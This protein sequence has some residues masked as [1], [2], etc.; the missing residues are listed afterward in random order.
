MAR[1]AVPYG[2]AVVAVVAAAAARLLLDPVLGPYRLPFITFFAAVALAAWY[3][4]RGPGLV[5]IVLSYL[6]AD[7]LYL[8]PRGSILTADPT[9]E[10]VIGLVAFF[11]VSGI[12]VALSD[13]LRRAHAR[14]ETHAL[15][16]ARQTQLIE[17]TLRSIGDAVIATDREGTISFMNPVAESLT[18][19]TQAEARERPLADVFHIVN[20]R[21]RAPAE[22]PHDKVLR[23]GQVVGL[24][25]HTVLISRHG[26]ERPIADSAAPI[27]DRA[28]HVLGVVIVF[29]DASEGRTAAQ[30]QAMLAAIVASSDDA[31]IS[32]SL[33]GIITSWNRGAERVFGYTAEEAIG[34]P[35]AMLA[36]PSKPE[37]M[38]QI[39]ERIRRGEHLDHFE[40]TRRRKD[41]QLV[42]IS[43]TVSPIRDEFGELIGASKVARDITE[44]KRGRDAVELALA[45]AERANRLKDEFLAVL[46]H[47]IRTP[48]NAILGWAQVL[49]GGDLSEGDRNEG[50]EVIE[51]NARAQAQLIA[52]L[53]DMS[54]IIS[55]RIELDIKPIDLAAVIDSTLVSLRP[56]AEARK[57]E[58]VRQFAHTGLVMGD[59]HRLQ[60]IVWNLLSNA[61]KFTPPG[62]QVRMELTRSDDKVRIVVAD[63]GQGIEPHFLPH[64]FE[65]FRQADS[66]STRTHGGLGLGLAI[67][68]HLVELHRGEI[69]AESGGPGQ[70]STFTVTLP[71]APALTSVDA[72][73]ASELAAF[74]RPKLDGLRVL[75]VDDESDARGLLARLF[76]DCGAQVHTAASV[77][78][79]LATIDSAPPDLLVSDIGMPG[80]D[81]YELIRRVRSLAADRGGRIPAVALTAFARSSDRT[82][83]LLAGYDSHLA[84]PIEPA[85][86]LAVVA[87]LSD[88]Q[89]RA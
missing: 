63:N 69:A 17:V 10:D 70:G 28:G 73:P 50:L 64:V 62:G 74:Q 81:G 84:K 36:D 85:E 49:R 46:S 76:A 25:N 82:R 26:T 80:V 18:G 52:D 30:A 41:G 59:G 39:L 15:L 1:R 54:R 53:L 20:E 61:I 60:Q 89:T 35:I 8:P 75:V 57:I 67:V 21:T 23:S 72:T 78:E 16:A 56:L 38:R 77:P 9:A 11:V 29:R 51:R 2:V 79:A 4:G 7:W 71:V 45:E 27:M 14:A 48:L 43:L 12:I 68:K 65:R 83:A 6:A 33:A 42:N 86:L 47:E 55:G 66:S 40:T 13:E 34:R 44:I 37:E 3:G 22:D 58:I 88:R 24:A 32:K 19:W 5:A 87:A 31:I